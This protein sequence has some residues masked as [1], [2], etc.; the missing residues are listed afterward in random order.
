MGPE[1]RSLI[2]GIAGMLST[3]IS[4]GFGLYF[5]ARARAA[6]MRELLYSKQLDLAERVVKLLGRARV[7]AVLL[8]PDGEYRD[9]AEAEMRTVVKRLSIL[10]DQT[11]VL[12]P[13]ELYVAAKQATDAL[14]SFMEDYDN[15]KDTSSAKDRFDGCNVKA[16]LMMRTLL[17]VDE[18]SD[19]SIRL[20]S[21][22]ESLTELAEISSDEFIKHARGAKDEG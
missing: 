6:P 15:D 9:Q 5:T 12:F 1:T 14:V 16:A 13:T 17:G 18:L 22:K 2:L 8:A 4:A 11:A 21:K 3:L 10:S 19:E 7:F 20:F